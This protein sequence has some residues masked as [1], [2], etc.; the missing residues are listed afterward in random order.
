MGS[1]AAATASQKPLLAKAS[2]AGR[3]ASGETGLGLLLSTARAGAPPATWI[4]GPCVLPNRFSMKRHS[5]ATS[6]SM[7]HPARVRPDQNPVGRAWPARPRSRPPVCA[8]GGGRE[9]R[10][11]PRRETAR[12]ASRATTAASIGR[13]LAELLAPGSSPHCV[14]AIVQHLAGPCASEGVPSLASPRN[15]RRHPNIPPIGN[16]RPSPPPAEHGAGNHDPQR[17]RNRPPESPRS[18]RRYQTRSS[19]VTFRMLERVPDI[20]P[21]LSRFRVTEI[22]LSKQ[23][24]RQ[25]DDSEIVRAAELLAHAKVS[26]IAW[27]GTSAS[28]LGFDRDERLCERIT[29]ATG[30]RPAPRCWPSA[31]SSVARALGGSGSSHPTWTTC[32][33][34]S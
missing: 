8:R 6:S 29:A 34:K 33:P 5:P 20:T 27:N 2:A 4:A 1:A 28:W 24:L 11:R 23:A 18:A 21:H 15:S 3:S 7:V 16:P 22:A 12:R 13:L 9:S 10:L 30:L 14:R 25:F 32:R 26:V 17:P 31:I 19:T